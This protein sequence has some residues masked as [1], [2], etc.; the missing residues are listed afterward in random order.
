MF[1]DKNQPHY[2]LATSKLLDPL[3]LWYKQIRHLRI[4]SFQNYFSR[5]KVSFTDNIIAK[6]YCNTCELTKAT[7]QYNR[8]LRPQPVF[9]YSEIHIDLVGSITPHS[10]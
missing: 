10:F 6:F 3:T 8:I 9:K 1:L 4:D 5:L 7:K 2:T